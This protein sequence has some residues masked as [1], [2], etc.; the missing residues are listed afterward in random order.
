MTKPLD[1]VILIGSLRAASWT[2]KVA[3]AAA[4]LAPAGLRC[5]EVPIAGLPLYNEDLD[6]KPPRAWTAFRKAIAGADAVLI[7][8]PEYNRSIPACLKNALDIGS[9]PEGENLWDGKPAGV[10]SVTPYKMGAFGAN[11]HVRQ[12][13]VF[14]NMPAMAQP[15]AYIGD[16]E[17]LFDEAG[18][19]RNKDTQQFLGRFMTAFAAW[20]K[21]VRSAP[22]GAD[23]D[24]FMAQREQIAAAYSSGDPKPLDAIAATGGKVTFF[25]PSGGVVSGA[26]AVT[27]KYDADA[28]AFAPGTKNRL[29]VLDAG[30]ESDLG[31]WTGLQHFDGKFR[32]QPAKMKLRVTEVFRRTDGEWKLVHRHADPAGDPQKPA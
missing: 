23:F 9:R 15:E 8:T 21:R 2:R 30:A 16:A 20:A 27:A 25:P 11:H 29:E 32:G 5:R 13:L 24:A 28:K 26:R 6:G 1:V 18:K 19:L 7:A 17:G 14:L 3:E 31:F 12:S 10:I 22:P 4:A